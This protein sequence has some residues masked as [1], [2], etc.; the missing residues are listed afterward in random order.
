MNDA[1]LND[2][3]IRKLLERFSEG[4]R[5]K[6][7]D[8]AKSLKEGVGHTASPDN[9]QKNEDMNARI[10]P[11]EVLEYEQRHPDFFPPN[12]TL[13]AKIDHL[14]K[15]GVIQKQARDQKIEQA[16]KLDA[17][18]EAKQAEA[19]ESKYR[20][21]IKKKADEIYNS[22]G[23]IEYCLNLYSRLWFG[24]RHIFEWLMCAFANNFVENTR[25]PIHIFV[26]GK[27]GLGKSESV[28]TFLTTV[29]EE[30]LLTGSFSRKAILYT[31]KIKA[32]S[33]IFQDDHVP[34]DEEAEI[35]RGI[36]SGWADGWTHNTVEKIGGENQLK[37]MAIPKRIIKIL[38]NAEGLSQSDREGQD[39]SRF[40]TLEVS[41]SKEDMRAIIGFSDNEI[42]DARYETEV[43]KTVWRSIASDCHTVEIP[44]KIQVDDSAIYKIREYKRF[45]TLIKAICVL[46]NIAVATKTEF[47]Q[48]LDLW[49]YVTTMIDN[50]SAGLSKEQRAVLQKMQELSAGGKQV[51][52]SDL[53]DRLKGRMKSPN[54]YR[55]LRGRNGSW[56]EPRGGILS[57]V[58]GIGI[59]DIM[60]RAPDGNKKEKVFTLEPTLGIL[61]NCNAYSIT[62]I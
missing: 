37:S 36:L 4:D 54:I 5:Q 22:G 21:E 30:Y 19:A 42:P 47:Q 33:I 51:Y 2:P 28:K 60:I 44:F 59:D 46:K 3:E 14:K 41:R 50:E 15:I 52:M 53:A 29:P 56:E 26:N 43:I 58:K 25:E 1:V 31:S 20:E 32:G 12:T 10:A 27:S 45:I 35:I 7:I 62:D 38:T 34:N 49:S 61:A 57:I 6:I 18:V 16:R 8:G 39:D 17:E 11:P 9:G 23:F 24:D 13:D 40:V 55:A 48:A